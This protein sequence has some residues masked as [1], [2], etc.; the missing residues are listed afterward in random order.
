MITIKLYTIGCPKCDVLKEKLD[1]KSLRYETIT[2]QEIMR[3]KGYDLMPV[4]E[5]NGE[6]MDFSKAMRWIN[7]Q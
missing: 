1:A 3:V 2:D 5:V 4:L 7:E 6:S